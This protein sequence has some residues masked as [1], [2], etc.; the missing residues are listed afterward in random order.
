ML[1][2]VSISSMQE[3]H[4]HETS[5]GMC[6]LRQ[7]A[8]LSLRTDHRRW[9]KLADM[10][11]SSSSCFIA[12]A[13]C[14]CPC[15]ELCSC[16]HLTFHVCALHLMCAHAAAN[17]NTSH[18]SILSAGSCY[19]GICVVCRQGWWTWGLSGMSSILGYVPSKDQLHR[20]TQA[21]MQQ[22]DATLSLDPQ[23]LPD[24]R[25]S[26]RKLELGTK[27]TVGISLQ[28]VPCFDQL[29]TVRAS[30]LHAAAMT[31]V[32]KMCHLRALL[33]IIKMHPLVHPMQPDDDLHYQ[34]TFSRGSKKH[35]HVLIRS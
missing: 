8:C 34:S 22:L 29:T 19:V 32:L 2:I 16:L 12:H 18:P 14:S 13:L 25:D 4:L 6:I 24:S 30:I 9:A 3:P 17:W 35:H 23:N 33:V 28:C 26:A 10:L 27:L 21:E 15:S 31:L 1:V 7:C 5:A 11:S 20:P